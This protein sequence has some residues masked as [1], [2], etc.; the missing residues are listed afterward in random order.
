MTRFIAAFL[1]LLA[2]ISASAAV[3]DVVAPTVTSALI[4]KTVSADLFDI[5]VVSGATAGYVMVFDA[6]TVPADGAVVPVYCMP[7]AANTG[8]QS[9]F[10][11]EPTAFQNGVV[12]VFSSTGCFTKT[13][14][15]TAYIAA[16]VR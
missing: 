14:S 13:A 16:Y 6:K 3:G 9:N 7:L 1:A 8:L 4:A 12:V 5:N 15:A 2:P 10:R 11:A